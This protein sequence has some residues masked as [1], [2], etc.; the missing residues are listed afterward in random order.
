MSGI[1]SKA[2]PVFDTSSTSFRAAACGLG[3]V[4]AMLV[5]GVKPDPEATARLAISLRALQGF[6]MV[7]AAEQ[8]GREA[9]ALGV[10]FPFTG[11]GLPDFAPPP[12]FASALEVV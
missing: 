1:L 7:E 9:I 3:E 8:E 2:A 12:P 6:L 5:G 4:I 10:S 11:D